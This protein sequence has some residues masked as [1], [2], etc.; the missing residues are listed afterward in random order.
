MPKGNKFK[1]ELLVPILPKPKQ[2]HTDGLDIADGKYL[3]REALLKKVMEKL[4]D[5]QFVVI[6]S[7]PASGKTS[8]FEL[9]NCK[10]KLRAHYVRCVKTE[11]SNLELIH[12]L[13]ETFDILRA[14]GRAPDPFYVF[15]DDAQKIYDDSEFWEQLI[16]AS[17][18]S[19]AKN[20]KFVISATHLLS[21]RSESPAD[22]QL[23]PRIIRDDL[24]IS[25]ED[26]SALIDMCDFCGFS[27]KLYPFSKYAIVKEAAGLIG[28]VII[29]V[30][31]ISD[32]F[33]HSS[34]EESDVL[35]YFLSA[36]FSSEIGRLFGTD[37][38]PIDD[39]FHLFLRNCFLNSGSSVL[40]DGES[41]VVV[42]SLVKGGALVQTGDDYRFSSPL[43]KRFY[44]KSIF[45]HRVAMQVPSDIFTLVKYGIAQMSAS[46]L[47]KSTVN[48]DDFPK[49]AVFRHEFM[50]GL[51][52]VLPPKCY[53]C[54]ELSGV[55]PDDQ[56]LD[57]KIDGELDLYINGNLRWGIELLVMG[58]KITEHMNRFSVP[59]GK[60]APLHVTNY[61]VVDFR[62][63]S[64]GKPTNVM[65]L[66]K[67]V[68]VVFPLGDFS[69][70]VC[71]FGNDPL[72]HIIKLSS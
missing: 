56:T 46:N 2:Y 42:N 72:N 66:E 40:L 49:E 33:R 39:E 9:L 6:S 22:L 27:L 15:L 64:N 19:T 41:R 8:L 4:Q 29:S 69:S 30:Y 43:A 65:A 54:P 60:Y 61:A 21:I 62:R 52:A 36:E 23:F 53:I 63:S 44:F 34:P 50:S 26:A 68:S 48:V 5:S 51:A 16:I 38:M 20:F 3:G 57:G 58:D 25:D 32:K 28:A 18:I 59:H 71:R 7:P 10:Y 12:Q 47:L 35:Q 45:P 14:E 67:R 70:C 55:F 24:L 11:K 17:K 37:I 31:K 1:A 13:F